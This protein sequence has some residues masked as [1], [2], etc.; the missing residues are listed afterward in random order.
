MGRDRDID[1]SVCIVN[2]NCRAML[3]ACLTSLLRQPQGARLEVIVVDN[4]SADGAADL[5]AREFAE[6]KL[7]RNA[8]NRGF[9]RA[10]NQAAGLASGRYL[11]FLNNDTVVPPGTLGRLVA[12]ADDH[13]RV[14]MIGPRLRGGDGRFQAS[15]RPRPTLAALLYRTHLFRLTGLCRRAYHRYRREQFDPH[16][17][18]AVETLMGAALLLP[19][20][21]FD[22]CGPWDEDFT[23][24]GED[25][26]FS[27]CVGRRYPLVFLPEVEIVHYGG[28]ST[29]QHSSYAAAA[30][31]AGYLQ[32]LRKSGYSRAALLVYKLAVTLDMPLQLALRG[33]EY[34]SRRM[35]GRLA[36]AQKSLMAW[37]GAWHFLVHGMVTFWRA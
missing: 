6:V 17:Q 30:R 12:F 35:R 36:A 16:H 34:L 23:F 18:R 1:V 11:F 10:N 25:L 32:F 21:V 24:G 2:W 19:R 8:E 29:R 20:R 28:V 31:A 13:P 7:V 4:G 3:R 27:T 5:A 37:R 22:E 14:G 9:A 26:H 33:G 15:Y